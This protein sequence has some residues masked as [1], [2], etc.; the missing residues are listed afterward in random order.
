MPPAAFPTSI[1]RQLPIGSEIFLDH[2][3]HFV[4][5]QSAAAEALARAGFAP[6]PV[7]VQVNPDPA[8]GPP[9]LT[10]TGNVCAM[11]RAGYVEVLF[12]TADT[13]LGAEFEGARTRY[14]GLHLVAFA[15][16]DAEAQ[17][18][19]LAG[20][21]FEMQPLVKMQRPVET[22]TGS[23]K[24]AFEVVRVKPGQMAEGRVQM[25]LHR[26]EDTVW[27]PRWLEHPN[28]ARG[29]AGLT[30]VVADVAEAER[31]YARFTGRQA[32]AVDGGC[33]FALDRGS[34]ELIDAAAWTR[35]WPAMPLPSLPYMGACTLEVALLDK[36]ARVLRAGGLAV[37][38][39]GAGLAV[40]FPAELG[41]GMWHF[42]E[43][44]AG[45]L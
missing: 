31:R 17:H 19:R 20:A 22:A 42:I 45:N 41:R 9:K 38:E 7:S 3:G 36:A 5:D 8:G 25:L 10:G 43:Q 26:T 4:A 27:Q 24:A 32:I 30:I 1:R 28:G 15:V 21:G 2:V 12:K 6:T 13:P 11:L 39:T 23:G 37:S 40:P 14:D 35:R 18:A 44:N 33:S 29:L 16:A 34:V